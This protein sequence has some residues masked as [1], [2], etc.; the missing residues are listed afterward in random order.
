[1]EKIYLNEIN[2]QMKM[3]NKIDKALNDPEITNQ[4]YI[5]AILNMCIKYEAFIADYNEKLFGGT[6]QYNHPWSNT[7]NI[8]KK[9]KINI[10]KEYILAHD[11]WEYYNALKHINLKTQKDKKELDNKYV[12][13][14]SKEAAEFICLSLTN[15]VKKFIKK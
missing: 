4:I 10:N 5:S 13:K 2:K 15:L 1:M 3:A 8:A 9:L 11:L 7:R 12:F 14:N 6:P